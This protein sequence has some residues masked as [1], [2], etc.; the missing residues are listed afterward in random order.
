MC[1]FAQPVPGL[2][3]RFFG[4]SSAEGVPVITPS[5]GASSPGRTDAA[6]APEEPASSSSAGSSGQAAAGETAAAAAEDGG[7]AV[8]GGGQLPRSF[9]GCLGDIA[10]LDLDIMSALPQ[11]LEC[12]RVV[13]VVSVMQVRRACMACPGSTVS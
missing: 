2:H 3:G 5:R 7:E 12:S 10:E 8:A 11:P 9:D 4:D 13:L 6:A 1:A